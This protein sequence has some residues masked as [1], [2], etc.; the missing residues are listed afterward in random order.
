MG[1][2][3]ISDGMALDILD[4]VERQG[5]T[6]SEAGTAHGLSR[7]S[8]AGLL[9]RVRDD[10]AASEAAPFLPGTGAAVKPDSRDGGMPVRWWEAGLRQRRA[11]GF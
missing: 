10:L 11:R 8:V 4:R 6:M 5:Q 9:R 7:D 1:Q 2:I 3:L